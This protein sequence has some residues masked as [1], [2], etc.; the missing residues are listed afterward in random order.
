MQT[1]LMLPH[2]ETQAWESFCDFA[3]RFQG[4]PEHTQ[5]S[6]CAEYG[7]T[8]TVFGVPARDL[9]AFSIHSRTRYC[10]EHV[11][12]AEAPLHWLSAQRCQSGRPIL[13][14]TIE[15]NRHVKFS[16]TVICSRWCLRLG[17]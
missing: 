3:L 15:D 11:A 8:S 5:S 2:W 1:V 7:K 16:R 9:R 12:L 10:E 6:Q 13:P 17:I 4:G 14:A